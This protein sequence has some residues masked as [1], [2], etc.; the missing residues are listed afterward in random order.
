[1]ELLRS[2]LRSHRK[3]AVIVT[4]DLRL[5]CRYADCII[6]IGLRY[7]TNG[8]PYGC[9]NGLEVLLMQ[10]DGSALLP[11]GELISDPQEHLYH[12]ITYL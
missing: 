5:A 4:H 12:A 1:M 10:S 6:P 8:R 7:D 11:A 9:V 3:S 2:H